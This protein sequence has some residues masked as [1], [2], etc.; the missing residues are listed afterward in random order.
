MCVIH[1]QTTLGDALRPCFTGESFI[2]CNRINLP[3]RQPSFIE[4]STAEAGSIQLE[5]RDLARAIN[6]SRLEVPTDHAGLVRAPR[7]NAQGPA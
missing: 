6:D 1:V 7:C 5:F 4:I 3:R 2:P